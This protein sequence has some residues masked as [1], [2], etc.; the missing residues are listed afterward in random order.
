MQGKQSHQQMLRQMQQGSGS[1]IPDDVFGEE[2]SPEDAE[3]FDAT[4]EAA[5]AVAAVQLLLW[6]G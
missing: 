5:G 2:P 4:A 6:P 1:L 3:F